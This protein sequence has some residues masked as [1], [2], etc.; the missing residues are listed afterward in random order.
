MG[1][2]LRTLLPAPLAFA[3]LLGGA[4]VAEAGNPAVAIGDASS[5]LATTP[6]A[7]SPSASR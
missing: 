6:C 5:S 7:K 2:A 1:H 3:A 4:A